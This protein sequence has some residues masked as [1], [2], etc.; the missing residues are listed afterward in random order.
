MFKVIIIAIIA[1]TIYRLCFIFFNRESIP[2]DASNKLFLF[3]RALLFGFNFDVVISCYIIAPFFI[4]V[5]IC[6]FSSKA[7][8]RL[9]PF[10]KW[11]FIVLFSAC[12][13]ICAADIPYYKQF[14]SHVSKEFCVWSDS[15]SFIVKL[16]FSNIAYWGYLVLFILLGVFIYKCISKIFLSIQIQKY[17]SNKFITIV[18]FLIL[19]LFLLVGMRG[20]TGAKSPIRIGTAFFSEYLFFNQLGLNPC[21]VFINSVLEHKKKWDFLNVKY[22]ETEISGINSN[23]SFEKIYSSDSLPKK[24]NVV[25]VLMESMAISKMG[26]YNCPHLTSRFD[27]IVGQGVFFNRFYSSGIHTFNGLFS[28]ETG[29]PAIMDVHP[30]NTYNKKSFKGIAYWLKQNGYTNYFF[31]CHDAQFDNME[32]FMKFNYFDRVYSQNDYPN[33]KVLSALGVPDHYLFEYALQK[34]DK[35]VKEKHTPFFSY[36]LTSSDH[37]PWVIP[38]DIPFKPNAEKD[39]D[40]ATQ[41]ADWA[42]GHFI[43]EAKKYDWFNN[44]LFVFVADHGLSIG[45]TYSMPLSFNHIPCVFYMPSQLKPDTISS[46]GGQIDVFPTLMNFLKIPFKNTSMG[47]D[48]MHEERPYMYFTADSKIGCIDNEYYYIHLLDEQ[49]ELLYR[50][51]NLDKH[52]YWEEYKA[53]ADSMKNYSQEMIRK[54][55]YI[56]ENKLY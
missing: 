38:A 18:V 39:Q 44:T 20:R 6:Q 50:F 40:K 10:F 49:K 41:Y 53:K 17:S 4:C 16:I 28:T 56:I 19:S 27:S 21:F 54:A 14:G 3:S 5:S 9:Y 7:L 47:I 51:E 13:L 8:A 32:G 45:Y 35:H 22:N 36:I 23:T 42:L 2:S 26:Y 1:F 55:N 33:E 31:T 43:E 37:G 25:V 12:M 30:L 11:Y 46:L 52:S 15:P 24:Y 48:L 29:F 34:M